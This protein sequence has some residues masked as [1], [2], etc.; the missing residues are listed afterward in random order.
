MSRCWI[1]ATMSAVIPKLSGVAH[2]CGVG[3]TVGVGVGVGVGVLVMTGV[4]LAATT[5]GVAGSFGISTTTRITAMSTSVMPPPMSSSVRDGTSA[6]ALRIA[7]MR[8]TRALSPG[9]S[10]DA[11]AS[12]SESRE[13]SSLRVSSSYDSSSS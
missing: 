12:P 5:G 9:S 8:R 10:S 1:S 2:G 4:S 11:N 3:A 7:R 13:S 6:M